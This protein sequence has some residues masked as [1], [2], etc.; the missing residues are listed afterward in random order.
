[1]WGLPLAITA[2]PRFTH[3]GLMLDLARVWW[4]TEG[5]KSVIEAMEYSK[6]NVLHL[7]LT[8]SEAFPVETSAFNTPFFQ[9]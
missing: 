2:A 8:D 4:S 7:H 9:P 1:M 5:V 3:R 6:L